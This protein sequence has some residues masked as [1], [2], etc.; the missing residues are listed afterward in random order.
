MTT[1]SGLVA[2]ILEGGSFD[3]SSPTVLAW[4]DRR[5]KEMVNY[6]R[7]YR[8]L[9]TIGPTVAGQKEY[10]APAGIVELLEV[11]VDGETYDRGHH[12]DV[13]AIDKGFLWLSG[14]GGLIIESANASSVT[15]LI[16]LPV[17]TVA[18][19]LITGYGVVQPPDLLIDNSV[20]LRVD[21]D[22]L[23]ALKAGVYAIG[24]SQPAQG[25]AND[26]A[27]QFALYGQGKEDFKRRVR[28][29]LR[30]SGPSRIRIAGMNA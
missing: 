25:Q 7:G 10:T 21:D 14:P 4:L 22:L 1:V 27:A 2:E 18:G 5:H 3:V 30:G 11:T 20:A 16:I 12:T 19:L 8:D 23:E 24:L 29:R 15:T 17:P 26:A 13:A 9:V 28:R 6:A